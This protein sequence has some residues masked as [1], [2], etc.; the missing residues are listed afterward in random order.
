M[1]DKKKKDRQR[2]R[3]RERGG[4]REGNKKKRT[5]SN[6]SNHFWD[7]NNAANNSLTIIPYILYSHPDI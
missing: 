4:E 3:Q 6:K 5:L 2:Q 1:F 7:I